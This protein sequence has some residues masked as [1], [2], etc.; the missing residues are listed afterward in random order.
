G[1]EALQDRLSAHDTIYSSIAPRL[2]VINDPQVL[3]NGYMAPHPDH[4]RARLS[5]S[6]MQFDGK[7]L[8]IRRAAPKVGE[9]TDEVFREAGVGEAE[10]ARLHASGALT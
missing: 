2:E 1:V 3:A 7:G 4:P 8:E 5:S 6:P 10:I 9:H